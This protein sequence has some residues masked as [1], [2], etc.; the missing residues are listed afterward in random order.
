M[1]DRR[2][3]KPLADESPRAFS[4]GKRFGLDLTLDLDYLRREGAALVEESSNS[5]LFFQK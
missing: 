1:E 5:V 3:E 4:Q 2:K